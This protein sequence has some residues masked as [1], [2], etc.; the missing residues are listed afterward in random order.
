MINFNHAVSDHR[1]ST[2]GSQVRWQSPTRPSQTPTSRC[3]LC[4]GQPCA[5]ATSRCPRMLCHIGRMLIP[6]T[7]LQ[8][9]H[10]V[11]SWVAVPHLHALLQATRHVRRRAAALPQ[12]GLGP[13]PVAEQH[14]RL[15]VRLCVRNQ[16]QSWQHGRELQLRR[17]GSPVRHGAAPGRWHWHQHLGWH[18]GGGDASLDRLPAG[19]SHARMHHACARNQRRPLFVLQRG[20]PHVELEKCKKE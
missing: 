7:R 15:C 12:A 2:M 9:F 16:R 1:R 19:D 3:G 13:G 20:L 4:P 6:T 8:F 5:V 18:R 17:S 11:G 10:A 14:H